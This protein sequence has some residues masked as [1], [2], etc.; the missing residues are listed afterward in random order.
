MSSFVDEVIQGWKKGEISTTRTPDEVLDTVLLSLHNT[1]RFNG[2]CRKDYNVLTHS[3]LVGAMASDI[4]RMNGA[5]ALHQTLARFVGMTHDFGEAIVG[6]MVYPLKRGEF[7]GAYENYK[8]LEE[9]ARDFIV[10]YSL[11]VGLV[12]VDKEREQVERADSF[13]GMMETL[14]AAQ[15]DDYICFSYLKPFFDN[16]VDCKMGNMQMFRDELLR[17]AE[18]LRL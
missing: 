14:G 7:E 15:T 16:A 2:L 18:Q 8:Q 12:G 9:A 1:I 17:L 13:F 3:W 11:G 4:A 10:K 5:D 6:D